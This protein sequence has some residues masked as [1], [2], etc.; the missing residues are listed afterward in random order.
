M[1]FA[2]SK[3]RAP[4]ALVAALLLAACGG[5]AVDDRAPVQSGPAPEVVARYQEVYDGGYVIPAVNPGYLTRRNA[6]TEVSYNGPDAPG[7]I[8]VDPYARVLYLVGPGGSATRYG[9]AVG[10]EGKGFAGDAVISRKAEWP[11]W[12]P[13]QNM[14][15]TEPEKYA[16]YAAGLPGGLENPLGARALYLYRGGRDTYYR[17]H[18]TIEPSSI[19]RATSAGC[20]RL[21]NQDAIDLFNRI[22][23]GTQVHVRNYSESLALEG[24]WT[25]DA[26][27]LLVPADSLA[28]SVPLTGPATGTVADVPRSSG[29]PPVGAENNIVMLEPVIYE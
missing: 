11:S 23:T 5:G 2:P 3:F 25:D 8:V 13:T 18:G 24:M 21:F 1:L 17:I 22:P 29:M 15:R 16:Q 19:G 26:N 14:I 9:I 27:G 7:T 20:I 12:Q 4:L 28:Q 10:R 6:R